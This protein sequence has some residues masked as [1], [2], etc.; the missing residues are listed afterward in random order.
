[1]NKSP[2]RFNIGD[3]VWILSNRAKQVEIVGMECHTWK[4]RYTGNS[5]SRMNLPVKKIRVTYTLTE[6]NVINGHRFIRDDDD[7]FASRED[8]AKQIIG[9]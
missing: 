8:L 9:D 5:L 2:F 6:K 7:V 3:K 4:E 1:M